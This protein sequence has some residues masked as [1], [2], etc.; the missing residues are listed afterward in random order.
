MHRLVLLLKFRN[1]LFSLNFSFNSKMKKN[2]SHW[3]ISL[4]RFHPI[5]PKSK[6]VRIGGVKFMGVWRVDGD[7]DWRMNIYF[8][9]PQKRGTHQ[10]RLNA[11]LELRVT[12]S[13]LVWSSDGMGAML[14]AIEEMLT[15]MMMMIHNLIN[16]SSNHASCIQSPSRSSVYSFVQSTLRSLICFPMDQFPP[17]GSLPVTWH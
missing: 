3:K 11:P 2:H 12:W 1:W 14:T 7:N 17:T 4:A 9:L 5:R 13:T 16:H 8:P 15:L 6:W 10:R